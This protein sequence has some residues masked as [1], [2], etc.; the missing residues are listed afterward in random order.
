MSPKGLLDAEMGAGVPGVSFC[1]HLN[2]IIL[3]QD[4]VWLSFS[5]DLPC[6]K[7]VLGTSYGWPSKEGSTTDPLHR[8][9]NKVEGLGSG[10]L[11][12]ARQ[13]VMG[14]RARLTGCL[15]CQLLVLL[16]WSSVVPVQLCDLQRALDFS[17]SKLGL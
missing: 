17:G 12:T 5:R 10:H 16:L 7:L 4:H 2:R 3:A 14:V 15:N 8:C 13:R 9:R 6:G 1:S 11:H